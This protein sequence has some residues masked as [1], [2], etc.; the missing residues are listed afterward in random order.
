MASFPLSAQVVNAGSGSYTTEHPGYD[1]AGRNKVPAGTPQLSGDAVGRPV[2]TN[3][4]WSNVLYRDQSDNIFAYPVGMRMRADGLTLA[5]IPKGAMVDFSPVHIS[6]GNITSAQTTVSGYSDWTVT[7]RWGDGSEYFDA[8][9]GLAMPFVYFTKHSPQAVTV[10]FREGMGTVTADGSTLVL[11]RG[12]NGA[13]F[14][15]YAPR[16]QH[17]DRQWLQLHVDA[18][19]QELLFGGDAAIDIHRCRRRGAPAPPIRLR[20]PCRHPCRLCL[21]RSYGSGA[22]RLCRDARREGRHHADRAAWPSASPLGASRP[23]QCHSIWPHLRHR[24]RRDA[25]ACRQQLLHGQ[26]LRRRAANAPLR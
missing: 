2:P 11:S 9:V 8:T 23:G 16:G 22:H 25:H 12:F 1:Q 6:V 14:A 3:D 18:R 5:Y 24:A 13:S 20:L 21:R 15:I 26:H 7:M 4:W 17:V 19:R 10:T